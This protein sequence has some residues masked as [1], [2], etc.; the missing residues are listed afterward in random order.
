VYVERVLVHGLDDVYAFFKR[1]HELF[2][3]EKL[4]N[5]SFKAMALAVALN[6]VLCA[7]FF[8]ESAFSFQGIAHF[9]PKTRRGGIFQ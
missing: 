2:F 7:A 5:I 1:E 3:E 6:E 8:Q 4:S 9:S